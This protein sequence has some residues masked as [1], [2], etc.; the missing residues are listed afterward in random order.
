MENYQVSARKYRPSTFSSVVGQKAL[1]ATLRNSIA[2]NRLAHAYLFCGSRGVGKTSC[3]RI[4]AKTIN[5]TNPT[6]DGN[7]CNECDSCRSFNENRSL[8][9][10][11]LDAASN[12]GVEDIRALIDQVQVLP[13]DGKYRVFIID[14]VHMLSSSAFNAFLKTLEEPPSY[15]IFIL[16]T[17]EKHK[18]LP[19]ILSR[20]QI[21]DFNRITINDMVDHLSYVAEQEGY[22]AER[23][24]LAVIASKADGA[25]RDALSIFD[26]V[27]AS[28]RGNITY[29]NAIESLNVLDAT[30]YHRLFEAFEK[31]DVPA[32]LNIYKEVRDR[33]FD[34]Q[35]FINGIGSYLRDLML[36]INDSTISMLEVDDATKNSMKEQSRRLKPDFYYQAM[37][38]CNEA[39]LNYRQ[40]SNKTFFVELLLIKLCQQLSPSQNSISGGE[41]QLKRV[42]AP[43]EN[44]GQTQSAT[45]P[46][47]QPVTPSTAPLPVSPQ[48]R[49]PQPTPP[50]PTRPQGQRAGS[51]INRGPS[52]SDLN[53]KPEEEMQNVVAEAT[54]SE[55]RRGVYSIDDVKDAW[56]KFMNARP[57]EHILINTMRASEPVQVEGDSFKITVENR[58][59]TDMMMSMKLTI[60]VFMRD[61]LKNDFWTMSVEENQGVGS[62]RTWNEKEVLDK[63]IEENESVRKLVSTFKLTL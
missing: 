48:V 13:T 58:V 7:P 39:D 31:E 53:R 14:E 19:T 3:A 38:L 42:A 45:Q 8:N 54:A 47:Q 46:V 15:V 11:E 35:F 37:S 12:N 55:M 27:A 18:I 49:H 9:I 44:I 16:A 41:G 26:Q 50:P 30:Y 17:T 34:S 40:S 51:R 5:C 24:A 2:T 25:M 32:A 63:L 6:A 60:E 43:S 59:Q 23:S 28:S 52:L 22:T 21:Y 33:G 29:Q 62:P 4:F 57:S 10:V 61:C 56:Y 20:C 1:T 36:A